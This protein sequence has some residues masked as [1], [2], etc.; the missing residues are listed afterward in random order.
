MNYICLVNITID[1][2]NMKVTF[3]KSRIMKSA[4]TMFKTGKSYRRHVFTFGEC[5]KGA[6]ADERKKVEKMDRLMRLREKMP[7]RAYNPISINQLSET[8]VNYYAYNTFN[9]D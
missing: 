8:L 1:I 6:W 2:I 9:N 5:L 3:N 7:Q 4:W